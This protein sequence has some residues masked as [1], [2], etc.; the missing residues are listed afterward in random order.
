MTRMPILALAAL[1][2]L[3]ANAAPSTGTVKIGV[4]A[5]GTVNWELEAIRNEGLDKKYGLTLEVQTLAG[6]DAGKIGLQ[7]DSLDLIATDWIWVASQDQAGADYRFIPYS[8]QAGALM[9]PA[10]TAIRKVADLKGKKIG[11][12]G[13]NSHFDEVTRFPASGV[14]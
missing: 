11:V 7:A 2:P 9:A 6:P 8:T 3:F 13:S 4:L 1:L 12:V 5:F 14:A 10:N